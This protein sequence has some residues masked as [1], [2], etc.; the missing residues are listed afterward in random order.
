LK[1]RGAQIFEELHPMKKLLITAAAM[2]SAA[3]V[4]AANAGSAS[5]TGHWP[6]TV[7]DSQGFNGTYCLEVTDDGGSG[8]AYLEA[9]NQTLYGTFQ[10]VGSEIVITNESQGVGEN[11]GLVF[12]AQARKSKLGKGAYDD[13]IDGE[14]YDTGAVAFGKKGGC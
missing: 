3:F 1:A 14:S 12:V 2:T 8:L 13:V 10:V 4:N 9:D 11:A 6:L 7:S 5:Y